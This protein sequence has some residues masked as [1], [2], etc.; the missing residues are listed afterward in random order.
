MINFILSKF[1]ELSDALIALDQKLGFKKFARYVLFVILIICLCNIRT[2]FRETVEIGIT[3]AEEIHNE[4]MKLRDEYMTDLTPLLTEFRAEM[5]ADRILYL[6]YHNSEENLDGI[7]FKFFDLMKCSSHY[8]VPEVPGIAYK[9]IGAS[10]YT[11]LFDTIVK[12]EVVT[13]SGEYDISFRKK[14]PG[15]YELFNGTD[16]SRQ[17]V[18]FSVPGIRRPIGFIVLEWMSDEEKVIIDYSSIRTFL[19]RINAISS[20]KLR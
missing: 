19:P 15:V 16:H 9:D 4:K 13:C 17:F 3:I 6:E 11:E 5:N 2:I 18:I 12:G 10:M 8:G 1:K 7:P 20:E 14:Y